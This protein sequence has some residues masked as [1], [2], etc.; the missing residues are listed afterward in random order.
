M[1]YSFYLFLL[2]CHTQYV[3]TWRSFA[4]RFST[5]Q[6]TKRSQ[7]ISFVNCSVAEQNGVKYGVSFS[8]KF[9]TAIVNPYLDVIVTAI[10]NSQ[11]EFV[12]INITHFDGCKFLQN[13]NPFNLLQ[14]L[15]NEFEKFSKIPNKCPVAKDT[16]IH[17]KNMSLDPEKFP[18]YVPQTGFRT[19]VRLW[20]KDTVILNL[21][22][23]G[24][25]D[26]KKRINRQKTKNN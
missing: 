16:E 26:T 5:I 23:N 3:T 4:F 1:K 9:S 14:I 22:V 2:M 21:M 20:E 11:P 7:L 17:V 19:E 6:C 13:T 24:S 10:R 8:L 12:I 18:P 15:R 25:V